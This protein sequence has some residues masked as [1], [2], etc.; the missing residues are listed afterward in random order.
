M[1]LLAKHCAVIYFDHGCLLCWGIWH[2]GMSKDI[3]GELVLF[4]CHVGSRSWIQVLRLGG[5]SFRPLSC[6]VNPSRGFLKPHQ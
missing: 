2:I 5:K 1:L 4:F 3:F 6:L